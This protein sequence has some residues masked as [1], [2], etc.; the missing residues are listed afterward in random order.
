V[1][2]ERELGPGEWSVLALLAHKPG[3]G[4]ALAEA[5]SKSG[6]IGR[7]WALGRALV[8]RAL[9]VLE[10]RGLIEPSGTEPGARGPNRAL[11]Q[12]TPRGQA[13]VARW[14]SEPV[15]HIRDVRSLLLLKLVL[16]ERAGL[17]NGP[18]LQAQREVTLSAVAALEARLRRSAGTEHVIV[19]FRLEST[20]SVVHFVDGLLAEHQPAR[21]HG[22][23]G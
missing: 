1:A 5:M 7:V 14:L 12:A 3:H 18:L 6:E 13:E 20:R 15:D 4:W 22:A 2:T 16:L 10:A 19:L 11:F 9:E 23:S 21:A 17:D 8:Y